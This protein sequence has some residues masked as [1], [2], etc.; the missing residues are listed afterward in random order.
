MSAVGGVLRY[1]SPHS[2]KVRGLPFHTTKQD[3]VEFFQKWS[4]LSPSAV[5]FP[6]QFYRGGFSNLQRANPTG[7]QDR[8]SL[9]ARGRAD[10][11]SSLSSSTVGRGGSV[12]SNA[13]GSIDDDL[14]NYTNS[15]LAYV[16][17]ERPQD[18]HAAVDQ[19]D[20]CWFR[21]QRKVDVLEVAQHLKREFLDHTLKD[22]YEITMQSEVDKAKRME[23]GRKQK[24]LVLQR[25]QWIKYDQ[26]GRRYARQDNIAP[27]Y[28]H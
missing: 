14:L 28:T 13:R 2:V 21:D 24:D 9:S 8:L 4:T 23:I 18:C 22:P 10:S 26:S 1:V 20:K 15:G 17:F 7:P 27:F 19:C 6:H 25:R 5:V 16:M 11:S 3:I 12:T